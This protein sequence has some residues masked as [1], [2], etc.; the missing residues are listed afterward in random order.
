MPCSSL[1]RK[2]AG[3]GEETD[4]FFYDHHEAVGS[5]GLGRWYTEEYYFY[6]IMFTKKIVRRYDFHFGE[7]REERLSEHHRIYEK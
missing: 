7:D 4:V 2:I 5:D 1:N 3:G 6:F